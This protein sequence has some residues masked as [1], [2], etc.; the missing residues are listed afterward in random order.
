MKFLLCQAALVLFMSAG[1]CAQDTAAPSANFTG[2]DRVSLALAAKNNVHEAILRKAVLMGIRHED[3]PGFYAREARDSADWFDAYDRAAKEASADPSAAIAAWKQRTRD[4]PSNP[5]AWIFLAVAQERE[6]DIRAAADSYSRALALDKYGR[7]GMAYYLRGLLRKDL[8]DLAGARKDLDAAINLASGNPYFYHARASLELESADYKTAAKDLRR[9]FAVAAD[10]AAVR[11]VSSG[12]ECE[13]LSRMRFVIKGCRHAD[14]IAEP[15]T[16]AAPKEAQAP[17]D[18]ETND[19]K[20]EQA[21]HFYEAVSDARNIAGED[22]PAP[23]RAAAVLRSGDTALVAFPEAKE[24]FKAAL[25]LYNLSVYI[26]PSSKA[27][28]KRAA[29]Y[30]G[31]SGIYPRTQARELEAADVERALAIDPLGA[32][33]WAYFLRARMGYSDKSE[34]SSQEDVDKAIAA[35]PRNA[36]FLREKTTLLANAG[37]YSEAAETFAKLRKIGQTPAPQDA[38]LCATLARNGF[39]TG[40]CRSLSVPEETVKSPLPPC[41]PPLEL[42]TDPG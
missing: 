8:D 35:D 41:S 23:E 36:C 19:E 26:D 34:A 14:A 18:Y 37:R 29:L 1:F 15:Q 10:T 24:A 9:F 32:R 39:D 42:I 38:G 33:G 31:L 17:W 3:M 5:D 7:W 21:L 22:A 16:E 6:G 27:Y 20:N 4:M 40:D 25:R 28:V 12:P 13:E 30:A 11:S 2:A